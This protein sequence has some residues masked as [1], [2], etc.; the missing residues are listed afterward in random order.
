MSRE[1]ASRNTNLEYEADTP[2][3]YKRLYTFA[4]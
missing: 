3:M 1:F 2:T 4:S